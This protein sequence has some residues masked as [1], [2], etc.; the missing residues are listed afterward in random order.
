V[1]VSGIFC[2]AALPWIPYA[3]WYLWFR[4]AQKRCICAIGTT[5]ACTVTEKR[6]WQKHGQTIYDL[7]Y[8]FTAGSKKICGK[9][10]SEGMGTR[11]GA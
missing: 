7:A 3:I 8:E 5:A 4:Q 2:L 6:E 1:S 11:A 10:G 9:Y